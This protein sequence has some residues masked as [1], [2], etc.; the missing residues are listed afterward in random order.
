MSFTSVSS[1]AADLTVMIFVWEAQSDNEKVYHVGVFDL[2]RWYHAQMPRNIRWEKATA[3]KV[4]SFVTF[5]SLSTAIEEAQC[6]LIVSIVC[7]SR[8]YYAFFYKQVTCLQ[9]FFSDSVAYTRRLEFCFS[10]RMLL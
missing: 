3:P 1:I 6:P 8:T 5:H 7:C 4:C 10:S 9:V 2:N